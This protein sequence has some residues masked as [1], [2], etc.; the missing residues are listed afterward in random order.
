M[1]LDIVFDEERITPDV[2]R[3][4]ASACPVDIFGANDRGLVV[5]PEEVDECT[6]CELCLTIAPAG[7]LVIRKLYKDETLVSS[8]GVPSSYATPPA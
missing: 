7:A 3:A 5:H 8:G 4:L 6:L 1:F 2:A